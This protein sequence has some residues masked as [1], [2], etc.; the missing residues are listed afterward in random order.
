MHAMKNSRRAASRTDTPVIRSRKWFDYLFIIFFPAAWGG[1][2]LLLLLSPLPGW[3]VALEL[4]GMLSCVL[5]TL[6]AGIRR[7]LGEDQFPAGGLEPFFLTAAGG[8]ALLAILDFFVFNIDYQARILSGGA[9]AAAFVVAALGLVVWTRWAL[10]ADDRG[11]G[12]RFPR[13]AAAVENSL[14]VLAA[15]LLFAC[16][17]PGFI[18]PWGGWPLAY[19]SLVPVFI[20]IARSG[21]RAAALYGALYAVAAHGL[22]NF[23][24]A[25]FNP[26]ALSVVLFFRILYYV[27]L[28]LL[29]RLSRSL[30]GR[31][32]FLVQTALWTTYEFISANGFIAY[33]YGIFGYS[34]FLVTPI[35]QVA[36]LTSVWGVSLLV[37]FPGAYL[38]NALAR[39]VKALPDFLRRTRAAP[40]A[41]GAVFTAALVYGIASR[42]DTAAMPTATVAC[43]Q[44]NIDP[45]IGGDP[46]YAH[47]LGILMQLSRR[48]EKDHPD[49]VIWPETALVPSLRYHLAV[50]DNQERYDRIIRPFLEF[51]DTQ[52]APYLIGNN[53]RVPT[54]RDSLGFITYD[55]YNA[56]LLMEGREIRDVYRKTHLVPFTEHFPFRDTLPMVYNWLAG[57]DTHFYTAGGE[58]NKDKVF[59]VNGLKVSSLVCFEDTFGE[60]SRRFAADGAELLVNHTNDAW[61][62]SQAAEVQHLQIAVFRAVETR[63]SLVRCTTSGI[64]SVIDPAGTIIDQRPPF[65]EDVMVT[66][67]PVNRSGPTLYVSAG[68]WCGFLAAAAAA[69]GL[70]AGLIVRLARRRGR[71]PDPAQGPGKP[72]RGA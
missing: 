41:Y 22:F 46:A 54:G 35:L 11:R 20:V 58:E 27:A 21:Y 15:A 43:I 45:W 36:S 24:L 49:L 23:W 55:S 52:R 5:W 57:E 16:S 26:I 12:L 32:A 42:P 63:R 33:S 40:I 67:V 17:F 51:M 6:M 53:D 29:L 37:I 66:K 31:G 3:L 18:F 38:G 47:S 61:S 34:Q 65:T 25:L 13:L 10:V 56:V 4:A 2:A 48:V 7:L 62:K 8:F 59:D 64:T 44:S 72:G 71:E 50:R 19:I 9:A 70:A 1:C 39:G 60:I 69:L 30:C 28:F 68:E 14:L